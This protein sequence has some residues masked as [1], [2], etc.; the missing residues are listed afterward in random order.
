LTLLDEIIAKTRDRVGARKRETPIDKLPGRQTEF[1]SLI[2]AI[3]RSRGPPVIAEV[4]PRSPSAGILRRDLDVSAQAKAY[5]A[6]GAVGISVL[7]EPEY[8][9]G[10]LE[11]LIKVRQ[12]VSLPV[13]QKD[14]IIDDYQILESSSYGADAVLLIV[15][16]LE[17]K[18][19]DFTDLVEDIGLEALVECHSITEVEKAVTV[20][21]T[22]IGV[23][24]RNFDT[25]KINLNLTKEL[26]KY[27]PQDRILVSESGINTPDDVRFLIDSGA[28]AVLIGTVLMKAEN[29]E[30][31]LME[32]TGVQ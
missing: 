25:M 12:N 30:Q 15:S 10:N 31:K 1:R 7:T 21:A 3:E 5:E 22:L 14:F 27:V 19:S 9:G 17:D 29:V 8:F 16:C 24:N 13:L 18:L 32:L 6:S 26:A 2:D 28:K 11:N 4:K 20:G 23:N